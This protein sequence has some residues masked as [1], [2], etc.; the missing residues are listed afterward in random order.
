MRPFVTVHGVAHGLEPGNLEAGEHVGPHLKEWLPSDGLPVSVVAED[1]LVVEER[2]E[3]AGILGLEVGDKVA[4][5]SLQTVIVRSPDELVGLRRAAAS[6]GVA[7]VVAPATTVRRVSRAGLTLP[8]LRAQ[9]SL[10]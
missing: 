9:R 7:E 8:D 4:V 10:R 3:D 6:E 2:C 1:N 5:V